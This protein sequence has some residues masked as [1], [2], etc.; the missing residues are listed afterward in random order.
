M[1]LMVRRCAVACALAL[2]LCGCSG[3]TGPSDAPAVAP[4]PSSTYTLLQMNL[5]LSGLAGC[6]GKTAY[7]AVVE[8]AVARIGEAHPD[9]VTFNEICR[10]DIARIAGRTGYHLRFSR[11]IYGGERLRCVRP[12]GRGLFGDAVLTKAAIESTDNQDFKAQAGIE[13]RRWLCV[14]TGVDVDVC[15][16]HLNTRS[17]IEVAGNEAQCVELAALLARRAAVRTVAFGGDVN[18]RHSCAPAGVWTRTDRSAE[19]AP[20]LQHAYG[21]G[22]LRSPSAEVVPAKHSDHDVLLVRADLAAP[23]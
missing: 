8:E 5:C 22:G 13:R 14:S 12:G 2:S 4:A 10:S 9:A 18:R 11:V 21:G 17:T 6:Y 1:N 19:Q 16:A 3:S 15:T 20:G 7:P 23:E